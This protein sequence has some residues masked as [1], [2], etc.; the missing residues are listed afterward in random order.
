VLSVFLRDKYFAYAVCIAVA[1]GLIYLYKL[2]YNHWL[3]NP[4]LYDL[5]TYSDLT[6]A[7]SGQGR[8]L[9]HRIYCL[10][11]SFVCLALAQLGFERKSAKSFMTN[12]RLG[13]RG[14]TCV[15]MVVTAAVAV[16]A[17]LMIK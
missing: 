11:L 17:G 5:W 4:A 15:V 14:W 16:A 10:A 2:G 3:Y 1:A 6:G 8:I 7:G 9:T 12:G 13:S